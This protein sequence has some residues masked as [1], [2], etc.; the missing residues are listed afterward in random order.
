MNKK[1]IIAIEGPEQIIDS[2]MPLFA[3]GTGYTPTSI[4]EEGEVVENPTTIIK[5]CERAIA[6]YIRSICTQ[7]GAE[8]AARLARE[9]YEESSNSALGLV[10][11]KME[12]E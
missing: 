1:L 9:T 4:S 7:V 11:L 3:K 2:A 6:D 10:S 5:H 8:D 12:V